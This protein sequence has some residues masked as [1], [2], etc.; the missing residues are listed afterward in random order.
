[1]T[2]PSKKQETIV[3]RVITILERARA[4]VARSVNTNTVI[5]YWVD[6]WQGNCRGNPAR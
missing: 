5:A 4:N 3:D 6:D 2:A 1:M